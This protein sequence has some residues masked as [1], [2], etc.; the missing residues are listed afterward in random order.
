MRIAL[1]FA[2]RYIFS[3]SRLGAANWVCVLS[4]VA[5]ALVSMALLIVLSVY[6]G[7]V[8]LLL[9][10]NEKLTPELV[11]SPQTGNSL[12]LSDDS[13]KNFLA[14]P[15]IASYS[16]QIKE[17]GIL[18]TRTSEELV[19]VW[20][21]P[22][23][24]KELKGLKDLVTEGSLPEFREKSD[25]MEA[26]VGFAL[27]VENAISPYRAEEGS[28]SSSP[29]SLVFPKRKGLINPLAPATAFRSREVAVVGI[30]EP[31][32][33][34]FDRTVFVELSAL[35]GLLGYK[36]KEGKS[37][38]LALNKEMGD[39]E[40]LISKLRKQLS[41]KYQ[42]LNREEQ[43][44]ELTFLIKMEGFMVYLVMSF[45]LLLATFNLANGLSMLV[46]EKRSE[47]DILTALG[48]TKQKQ[49]QIFSLSALLVS[50][51]GLVFGLMLGLIFCYLQLE[52]GFL[53]AGEGLM[54]Q[55][56][57]ITIK[58]RDILLILAS[59]FLISLA[60]TLFIKYIIKK[61]H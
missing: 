39:T 55:A 9:E 60:I 25:V 24:Q 37:L 40:E 13:L 35:Q 29:Y 49:E 44:A 47:L 30:M 36:A 31:L 42:L 2:Y 45:I 22:K 11:L 54:S 26:S 51:L 59:N 57:P 18:K 34:D 10:G 38:M 21:F 41:E 12:S 3:R 1:S 16:L 7:Y 8:T 6:N 27:A 58:T 32:R 33:E 17:R 53:R 20:G 19:E 14:L 61:F 23:G 28:Q 43:Q 4:A 56:F 5:I 48:M 15:E 46:I 52:F 50:S